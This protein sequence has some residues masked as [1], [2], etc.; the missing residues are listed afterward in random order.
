MTCF[1]RSAL[2]GEIPKTLRREEMKKTVMLI[3]ILLITS[4]M[5]AVATSTSPNEQTTF[6]EP[7][8]TSSE[9]SDHEALSP[10]SPS[11][12]IHESVGAIDPSEEII[13]AEAPNPNQPQQQPPHLDADKSVSPTSIYLPGEGSPDT[14]TVTLTVSGDGD[15]QLQH[16]PVDI[17][18]VMDR[19]GSMGGNGGTNTGTRLGDAKVAANLFLGNLDQTNDYSGLASFAT[20]ASLDKGLNNIHMITQHPTSSTE[21][22]VNALVATGNTAMG[23]GINTGQTEI[24]NNGRASAVPVMIVLSD[25]CSNWG[26]NPITAATNA[27]N[28]GTIIYS[29]GLGGSVCTTTMQQIST[30]DP[31]IPGYEHYYFAPTGSD[32]AGIYQNISEEIVK[33]AGTNVVVTDILASN[34]DYIPGTFSI[35][36][37]FIVGK[38]ITW[39]VG[40]LDVDDTWTVTFDIEASVCGDQLVDVYPASGVTYYCR[41]IADING[42]YTGFE[43]SPITFDGN[44]SYDT[45]GFIVQYDWDMDGDGIFETV[46]AGPNPT[47]TWGDDYSGD[48]GLI[49]QDN[50]GLWSIPVNTT[51]DVYGV[52]PQVDLIPAQTIDEGDTVTFFGHATDPGS[53]DLTFQWTWDSR[54]ICDKS[55]KYQNNPPNDDPPVSPDINPRN[56]LEAASCTYGDN[57]VYTVI[58]TVTDDDGLTSMVMTTLTVNNLDPIAVSIDH[59]YVD[60]DFKLRVTGEKWHNVSIG[61]L[62]NGT[63]VDGGVI[64]RYP[65]NP[66][67]QSIS[68]TTSLDI[69]QPHSLVIIFNANPDW[70]PINGQIKG[71]NPVWVT[72]DDTKLKHTFVV[73]QGGP[74]QTWNIPNIDDYIVTVGKELTFESSA[75]DPGSDD[76]T[77]DMDFDDGADSNKYYNNMG[78]NPPPDVGIPDPLKSPGGTF[79]FS[80]Q[81]TK[82]HTY[83]TAGTYTV[84]LRVTDDDGAWVEVS[85]T[86]TIS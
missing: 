13:V 56:V 73:S 35:A 16:F 82:T 48:V 70:N 47:F 43:G 53:D 3:S 34:V 64:E 19:S 30:N 79:P 77:F 5:L 10:I 85:T 86:L 42:P 62:E 7:E 37:N 59:V 27:K 6:E 84:T 11:E 18:L 31:L 46:N 55:T 2:E 52:V 15:P 26:S 68:F 63:Q 81:D 45:D 58:L 9:S 61:V 83:T 1:E 51:V 22:A 76:L 39:N 4:M 21:A 44:G 50:D 32:L 75:S 71:A 28:A 78:N 54:A 74:V 65:G 41:P 72:I 36:P 8:M 38:T 67:D 29:I 57:G 23:D 14:A 80:A 33:T 17:M 12:E 20:T 25:G 69:M 40:T 66:N 60:V 49:V 24:S